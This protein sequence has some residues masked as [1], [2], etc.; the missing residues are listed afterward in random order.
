M[1]CHL[2]RKKSATW[3]YMLGPERLPVIVDL[4]DTCTR[5]MEQARGEAEADSQAEAENEKLWGRED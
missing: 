3:P 1:K 4:C 5:L 2:C